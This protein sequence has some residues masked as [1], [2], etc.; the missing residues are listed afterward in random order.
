MGKKRNWQLRMNEQRELR[1]QGVDLLYQRAVLLRDCYHDQ[2][3]R[4]WCETNGVNE[5]DML[6]RELEDAAVTFLTLVAVL[7][8][9]PTAEEWQGRNLREMIAEVIQSQ[10]RDRPTERVSWKERC[11][12]AEKECERLR[13]EVEKLREMLELFTQKSVA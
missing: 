5:L 11:L 13:G 8:S 2:A 9:Y 4:E 10:K 12:S 1:K 6:D 3:F 7:E